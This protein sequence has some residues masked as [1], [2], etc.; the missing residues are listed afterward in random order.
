MNAH[1][2]GVSFKLPQA[3]GGS[4]WVQLIDTN[5]TTD[6]EMPEFDFGHDYVVTGRS[7]LLFILRPER[8]H[9]RATP[10]ERS[11]QRV[12][13]TLDDAAWRHVAFGF[14]L[15]SGDVKPAAPAAPAPAAPAPPGQAP[16]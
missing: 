1:T 9:Y 12:V 4:R 13:Q 14:E 2:D 8:T 6:G 7:F 15:K 3:S 11:F 5:R 10:A 16:R